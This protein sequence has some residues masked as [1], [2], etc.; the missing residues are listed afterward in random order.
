LQKIKNKSNNI[1]QIDFIEEKEEQKDLIEKNEKIEIDKLPL[2]SSINKDIS[3]IA[4]SKEIEKL[5]NNISTELFEKQ[6]MKELGIKSLKNDFSNIEK[7]NGEEDISDK[8]NKVNGNNEIIQNN[9]SKKTTTITYSLKG[10]YLRHQ[11]VPVYL[12]KEGGLVTINIL[13]DRWGKVVNAEYSKE[14]SQTSDPCLI[15]EAIKSSYKFL[16]NSDQLAPEKQAGFISFN[17][18]NQ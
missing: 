15:E 5:K 17:F 6:V 12:C 18:I 14:K 7:S 13:V 11:H 4:Q 10:R 9:Q 3:N 1:I 16:F 2:M 8:K